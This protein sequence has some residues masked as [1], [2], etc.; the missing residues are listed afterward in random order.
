MPQAPVGARGSQLGRLQTFELRVVDDAQVG[1]ELI[2]SSNQDRCRRA[3]TDIGPRVFV[4]EVSPYQQRSRLACLEFTQSL[5]ASGFVSRK[6][7][8]NPR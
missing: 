1:Q 2:A 3:P 6:H 5:H 4:G 8:A 7:H